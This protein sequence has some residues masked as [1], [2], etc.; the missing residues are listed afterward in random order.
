M[1]PV[2]QGVLGAV[3]AQAVHT[4]YAFTNNKQPPSTSGL[5]KPALIGALAGMAPDLDVLITSSQD[6]LLA[7]EFHR[8]FTHSLFFIPIGALLCGALFFLLLGKRWS[9]PFSIFCLWSFAG[10]GSHAL[11]DACTSYGT[12]LLWPL[13]N[14]R[15]AWDT[16]SVID[17]LFTLPLLMFVFLAAIK[18][19]AL[20]AQ[21]GFAWVF[22]YL[23][24]GFIQHDR[25]EDV[26]R[27][28]AQER[29]HEVLRLEVKPSFGNLS[30]WK[31][32]YETSERF[33]VDAVKPNGKTW[34]GESVPKLNLER[35]VPWLQKDSQQA[36]DV[37]RFRWFSA[38]YLAVYPNHP[39]RIGDVR[40]SMLPNEIMPLWGIELSESAAQD[41]HVNYIETREGDRQL[42]LQQLIAMIFE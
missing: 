29:G 4:V 16:V 41:Q 32:I 22:I 13:S 7:L 39:N 18:R 21:F 14:A 37:E 1:D 3:T 26:G 10:Y 23:G 31:L 35:D 24:F 2:S 40:Y 36:V 12:Q 15:F 19:K 6:L 11:L 20:V 27:L 33:Y 25:A 34:S 9:L 28:L 38:D 42:A 8:H 30:V 5:V 17:P